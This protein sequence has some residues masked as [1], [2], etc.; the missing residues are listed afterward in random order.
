M[1]PFDISNP[2]DLVK[3]L[4]RWIF[5]PSAAITITFI[6]VNAAWS[7]YGTF[8][9]VRDGVR[10]ARR[11]YV[12]ASANLRRMPTVAIVLGIISSVV[13]MALQAT[14][15]WISFIVG[16]ALSYLFTGDV[17]RDGPK[18]GT[19]LSS[20]HW[21][22]ITTVYVVA[23]IAALLTS[24]VLAYKETET[25]RVALF[26]AAPAIFWLIPTVLLSV[27][28]L[29]VAGLH[30]LS[31]DVFQLD[32]SGKSAMLVVVLSVAHILACTSTMKTPRLMFGIWKAPVP[33]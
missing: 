12:A 6:V 26:I 18:W 1:E 33:A 29:V 19:V 11:S 9:D 22:A 8:K 28:A 5:G 14:W 32:P 2:D 27:L 30:W 21:D 7:W 3:G 25:T 31:D 23:S 20:L 10:F 16:N 13:L 17:P 24:Y 4:L 15:L